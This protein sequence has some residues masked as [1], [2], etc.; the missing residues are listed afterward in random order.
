MTMLQ[1]PVRRARTAPQP[2]APDERR[3]RQSMRAQIARLDGRLSALIVTSFPEGGIAAAIPSG[4][5]PRV[6]SLA[7][8]ER[9]RDAL[10]R[11]VA[12]A[13][14]ML[15]RRSE[16][17]ERARVRLER[18]LLEPGAYRFERIT[19]RELGE[20]GC[21]VWRVVPRLGLI[22]MLAGWWHVKISSGCPLAT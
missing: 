2:L 3:A 14:A 5:G 16:Q 8:L 10:A 21:G 6:Q 17:Q 22:G 7:D 18:M 20:R 4:H 15:E 12:D 13:G 9:Q 11:R 1:T 19:Q